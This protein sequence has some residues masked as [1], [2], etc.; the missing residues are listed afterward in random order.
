KQAALHRIVNATLESEPGSMGPTRIDGETAE[1]ADALDELR[2]LG[3][4]GDRRLVIVDPADAFITK[5][6]KQLEAYCAAPADGGTLVLVCR[7]LPRNTRLHKAIAAA[8]EVVEC[9]ALRP[10]D[11]GPW[12]VLRSRE[13]Y[14][15]AVDAQAATRLRDLAGDDL[16]LLDNELAKLSIYV[17]GRDRIGLDDVEALVGQHREEKVFRVTD[18]MAAGDVR[19]AMTAWQKVLATDR[20]APARAVGGLS[21]VIRQLLEAKQA[22][23]SGRTVNARFGRD[24]ASAAARLGQADVHQL[25]RQLC[26]LYEL[27]LAC[28]T[29]LAEVGPAIETFI[30][31][32]TLSRHG[33]A[34]TV[35]GAMA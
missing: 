8:G 4:L 13:A 12:I 9:A 3:L 32:H 6:R 25:Q 26:D 1:L 21:Y 28:K 7:S 17:G 30:V 34:G 19:A 18:A 22:S 15:K 11:V 29:G 31:K 16:G 35:A 24:P 27:D 23:Q 2:T 33:P 5:Y 14:A 10:R 20:A